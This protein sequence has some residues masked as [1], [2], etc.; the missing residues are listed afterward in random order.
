MHLLQAMEIPE[1]ALDI[2]P[3]SPA[4]RRC[5]FADSGQ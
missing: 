4:T 1:T 2:R 3:L 5:F